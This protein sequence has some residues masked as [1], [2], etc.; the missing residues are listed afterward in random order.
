MDGGGLIPKVNDPPQQGDHT[1]APFLRSLSGH[2]KRVE[3]RQVFGVIAVINQS[4][5]SAAR[6]RQRGNAHVLTIAA[7]GFKA[8]NDL[9]QA[10]SKQVGGD[11]R[12]HRVKRGALAR[13]GQPVT[14]A[15]LVDVE[16]DQAAVGILGKCRDPHVGVG[17]KPVADDAGTVAGNAGSHSVISGHITV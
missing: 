5:S 8:G 4:D 1:A 12:G 2:L 16:C 11:K 14:Q 6:Q 13:H 7:P 17:I 9:R 10:H 15:L 3:H